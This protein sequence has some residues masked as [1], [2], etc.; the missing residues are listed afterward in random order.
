MAFRL[1][2]QLYAGPRCRNQK[3]LS[4]SLYWYQLWGYCLCHVSNWGPWVADDVNIELQISFRG[5]CSRHVYTH[6]STKVPPISFWQ[7]CL[8]SIRIWITINYLSCTELTLPP[9]RFLTSNMVTWYPCWRRTSAHLS[10]A[11][12]A[13]IIPTWRALAILKSEVSIYQLSLAMIYDNLQEVL[14][15]K[16]DMSPSCVMLM[17]D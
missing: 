16:L 2:T 17:R 15:K 3:W 13:P 9:I 4:P 6:I 11:T 5:G 10:P 12:P 1:A 7:T 14:E 8:I